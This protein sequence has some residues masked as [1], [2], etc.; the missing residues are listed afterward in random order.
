MTGGNGWM[1]GTEIEKRAETG[2][3]RYNE[4]N[5]LMNSQTPEIKTFS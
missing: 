2:K 4:W 5:E 1:T 3:L